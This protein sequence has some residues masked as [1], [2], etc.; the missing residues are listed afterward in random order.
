MRSTLVLGLG[1]SQAG[2]VAPATVSLRTRAAVEPLT[3]DQ[4]RR[5]VETLQASEREVTR[6]E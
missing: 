6:Q 3:A 1:C 5:F 2:E 4:R